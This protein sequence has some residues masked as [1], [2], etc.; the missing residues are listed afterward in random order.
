MRAFKCLFSEGRGSSVWLAVATGAVMVLL[1][2]LADTLWLSNDVIQLVSAAQNLVSG[3]GFVSSI[4]YY[5]SQYHSQL[6][7]PPMTVW[8]PGFVWILA[9]AELAGVQ[10]ATAAVFSGILCHGLVGVATFLFARLAGFSG[11]T[12]LAASMAWLFQQATWRIALAGNEE[13]LFILLTVLSGCVLVEWVKSGQCGSSRLLAAGTL[14]AMAILVRYVGVLWVAAVLGWM[15]S[16][17]VRTRRWS[18]LKDSAVFGILPVATALTLFFRNFSLTGRITGGQY[19][20]GEPASLL[21]ATR[22]FVWEVG[23]MLIPGSELLPGH[24]VGL[25]L[26]LIAVFMV[27]FGIRSASTFMRG[28]FS[29]GARCATGLCLWFLAVFAAFTIVN[30]LAFSSS[31]IAYHYFLP[32]MP[33]AFVILA[34]AVSACIRWARSQRR[35]G[36]GMLAGIAA[37]LVAVPIWGQVPILLSSWPPVPDQ[38]LVPLLRTGLAERFSTG[39]TVADFLR[40]AA[41]GRFVL[42][43]HHEHRVNYLTGTP[44]Y[45][46]ADAR[47]THNVWTTGRVRDLIVERGIEWVLFFPEAYAPSEPTNGNLDFFDHLHSGSHPKWLNPEL[48]TGHVSLYSVDRSSLAADDHGAP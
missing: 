37:M 6:S 5:D 7:P 22:S 10:A 34:G 27:V 46:L 19:D 4:V 28:A 48:M 23:P 40:L 45:G 47:F 2:G 17:L 18:M 9:L 44:A 33:F 12:A 3:N 15:L 42:L 43:A 21:E 39:E 31:L 25:F 11:W 38:P 16:E 20:F 8:P 26:T 13:S 14:A 36:V 41:D 35:A 29:D 1:A 24:W 32:L 30:V